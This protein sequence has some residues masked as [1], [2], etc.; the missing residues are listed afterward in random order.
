M[1]AWER[2][3]WTWVEHGGHMSGTWE[4]KEGVFTLPLYEMLG[5]E[6]PLCGPISSFTDISLCELRGKESR[7]PVG[8]DVRWQFVIG[9][10][11]S[12]DRHFGLS[13]DMKGPFG[14]TGWTRKRKRRREELEG[15]LGREVGLM[16]FLDR[17]EI[18]LET[19]IRTASSVIDLDD[20]SHLKTNREQIDRMI[21]LMKQHAGSFDHQPEDRIRR[22]ADLFNYHMMV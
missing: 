7:V 12:V 13:V 9:T 8:I 2:G 19:F 21:R 14:C 6:N 10:E 16:A 18:D 4:K 20:Q 5:P 22:M 3:G 11:V 15:R 17:H 1:Y